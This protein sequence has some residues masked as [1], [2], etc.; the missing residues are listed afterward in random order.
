MNILYF[1]YIKFFYFIIKKKIN[2]KKLFFL[3]KKFNYLE[4]IPFQNLNSSNKKYFKKKNIINKDISVLK[5]L[6]YNVQIFRFLKIYF[7]IKKSCDFKSVLDLGCGVGYFQFICNYFRH[8]SIGIDFLN[9]NKYYNRGSIN[10]IKS[11]QK[12][13]NIKCKNYKITKNFNPRINQKFDLIVSFSSNFDGEYKFNRFNYT[14]WSFN[15][16][17]VFFNNLYKYLNSN[18]KFFINFNHKWEFKKGFYIDKKFK[19]HLKKKNMYFKNGIVCNF[20]PSKD[21]L[22]LFS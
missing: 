21:L 5:Y 16:Y 7:E 12:I 2:K 10:F 4:N 11:Y 17:N 14:P 3:K 13:L 15:K 1:I 9:E 8:K 18:G 6:N 19:N 22:A 20:T